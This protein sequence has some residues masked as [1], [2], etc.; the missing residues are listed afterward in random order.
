MMARPRPRA[1]SRGRG[2]IGTRRPGL[3]IVICGPDGAGKSTLTGS[4]ANDPASP[5][6]A[7][8]ILHW[9]PNVLPRL[10]AIVRRPAPDG[11]EPHGP[12]P[13]GRVVSMVRLL[14]Y[15]LDY[16]IGHRIKIRPLRRVGTLVVLER[17]YWDMVV[18]PYRYRLDIGPR[19]VAMLGRLVPEPDLTLVLLGAPSAI[20]DRKDELPVQEL[21]R[22]VR[23][24]GNL[25]RG[26]E[27]WHVL[28]ATH[29]ADR[30]QAEAASILTDARRDDA[31]DA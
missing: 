11:S 14:Y 4:L 13:Y 6:D 3:F 16:L 12:R 26:R 23:A 25:A 18:D 22:Q 20:V 10:G 7:T 31:D 9:R 15:W 30:I 19:I 24:W 28:D 17:G 29:S 1:R 2:T 8:Q 21:G 27:R 5:F